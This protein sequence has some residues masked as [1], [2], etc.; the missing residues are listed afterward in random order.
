M[1]IPLAVSPA[2]KTPGVALT[3][4]LT[5][6]AASPGSA[7]RKGLIMATK[8]TAGTI[9]ADTELAEG[10]AGEKAAGLLLGPGTQGHLAAKTFFAEHGLAS[11]AIVSP[12]DPAGTAATQTV[13][14][15][16]GP[17]TADWT[18]T[19]WLCGRKVQIIWKA[20]E[21]DTQGAAKLALAINAKNDVL[22]MTAAAALGVVTLTFKTTGLIGNDAK[23]RLTTA[24]GATG[25]VALGAATMT[26][27]L[28]EI[29]VSSALSTVV[30]KKYDTIIP[31]LSNADIQDGTASSN[32]G[33]IKTDLTARETGFNAKLQQVVY[34]ATGALAALKTGADALNH[35]DAQIIFCL[36]GESL[37]CEFGGAEGGARLKA[38]GIKP[39]FNRIGQ[40]YLATLYGAAD[41]SLNALTGPEVEDALNNGIS[42]VTYQADDSPETKRPITTYHLD[43]SGNP[44]FRA[45]DTAQVTGAFAIAE[46]LKI[47]LAQEYK[48]ATLSKD[49]A[50]GEDPPPAGVV[51]EG[52]AESFADARIQF[53]INLGVAS[54]PH[55]EA[56]KASGT[57]IVQVNATDAS[58]L[59][60]VF[61]ITIVPPLAKIGVVVQNFAS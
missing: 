9:T 51:Q 60:T 40:A 31:C 37:G 49:I 17:P 8:G 34:G 54:G 43:E 38:E 44:D 53:W 28:G 33:R 11:L 22:P 1:S 41:L 6:G 55:Y 15:A 4:D 24:D 18:V 5:P 39:N 48:G 3:V 58:Q 27:G 26:G 42:P 30:G 35:E 46:D 7:V 36:E 29:D 50:P 13:T 23:L 59:D 32:P 2:T 61:P 14:F 12:A 47:A 56:A 25:T 19:A 57:R 20:G 45:Y 16:T 10:V 21:T 52:D